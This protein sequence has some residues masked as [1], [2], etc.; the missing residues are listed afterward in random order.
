VDSSRAWAEIDLD[1]LSSNLATIRRR[2]EART[3]I[4]LVAK[5][6]AY[7]HGAIAIAHHAQ[8]CGVGA[9]GVTT[10]AEALELRQAGIRLRTV[11]LGPVF[12]EEAPPAIRSGIEMCV[13]S[14]ELGRGVERAA[15]A[16]G[17]AARVHVKVDTGMGRLGVP[18]DEALEL[19]ET[20]RSSPGLEL[21]GVMTHFASTEGASS[22][23]FQE[24]VR[25]F[26]GLLEVARTRGLLAGRDVW[27]HAANSA[28]VLSGIDPLYDAV[29]V[30][31]AAY[32][33]SADP[34]LR[35]EELR[36]ILAVR[37]RIVHLR[38]LSAGDCVGYGGTWRATRP[39]R[40][41]VLP[42]GYHDGIDWR[43]GNRGGVL[44]R[45][46]RAPMVGRISM[47]YTTVDVTDVPGVGLGDTVTLIGEDAGRRARVE[48]LA[49]LIGTI[50][51]EIT[52]T[53]GRRVSRIYSGGANPPSL[54]PAATTG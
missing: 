15:F 20:V 19:L 52:C 10:C 32:G 37:T 51:Y 45:G 42:M 22:A 7:G 43:L 34:G 46:R 53:I 33:V 4:M 17:R 3:A 31:I 5:A 14:Q 16:V 12:S 30:G 49:E 13:P 18:P 9:V 41:A 47:D 36:P 50:P 24:Q 40:I 11:I 29:R 21:A 48:E 25:R 28:A 39:T 54:C 35:S 8:R 23:A 2:I 26:Q 44:V 6:D 38:S 1:A 27:I